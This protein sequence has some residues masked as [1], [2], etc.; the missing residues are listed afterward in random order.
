MAPKGK[1]VIVAEKSLK[2]GRPGKTGD[3]SLASKAGSTRRFRAKSVEPHR[4]TWFNTQKESKY[5][6]E[7]WIDEGHLEL[8]FP[9]IW[10]KIRELGAGYIFNKSE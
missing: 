2:R 3:N 1:E 8:E 9:A 10:V 6:P 7:N 4:L 5:A